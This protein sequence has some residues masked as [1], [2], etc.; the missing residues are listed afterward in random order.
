MKDI[1][2]LRE[3]LDDIEI[4][5]LDHEPKV[6]LSK[7]EVLSF[8]ALGLMHG[9]SNTNPDGRAVDMLLDEMGF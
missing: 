9:M 8:Y 5:R 1:D 2:A 4:D 6:L 7:N 3:K